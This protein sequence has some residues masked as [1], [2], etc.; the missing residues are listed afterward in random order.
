MSDLG[1]IDKTLRPGDADH[2]ITLRPADSADKTLRVEQQKDIEIINE[3]KT[4]KSLYKKLY[5][6]PKRTVELI[7][8]RMK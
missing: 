6:D 7:D 2:D 1:D 4:K 5:D 8:R 3:L